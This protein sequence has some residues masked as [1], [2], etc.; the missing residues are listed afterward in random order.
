MKFR[1]LLTLL[2]LYSGVS[3]A[4]FSNMIVF[5][6][7][8]SDGGNFPESPQ[9]W[10]HTD[11]P[12]TQSNAIAQFYVPF[13]NPVDTN[14]TNTKWPPLDSRYLAEQ[15]PISNHVAARQYRSISWPQFF[16]MNAVEAHATQSAYIS[17]SE[18]ITEKK[19]P[20]DFSFNYAWGYATSTLHCVN[21]FYIPI[22][23]CN[24]N[25]ITAARENY[26]QNPTQNTYLKLEIPGIPEQVHLFLADEHAGKV[27]VNAQTQYVFWIGGNDLIIAS[28]ALLKNKNPLPAL[29]FLMGNTATHIIQSV[30]YLLKQLPEGKRP[31][32]IDVV[33]LFNPG[34]TPGFYHT[35]LAGIGNFSARSFNFWLQ[36]DTWFFNLF[37]KTKIIIIPTYRLYEQAASESTFKKEMGKTCQLDGGDYTQPTLIPKQNCA[38]FMFWNAVHPTTEMNMRV[39]K[40]MK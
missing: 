4:F 14:N 15:A 21:P 5:G 35:K 23:T 1:F 13:A 17:P 27:S 7:S 29:G 11:Q 16:L 30:R 26:I 12:K 2:F 24:A 32:S 28:N 37:S 36:V 39:A 18:L 38:G 34:L 40:I 31:K 20:A 3:S 9:I 19:I 6:D 33:E 10:W 25:S 8:L 22:H